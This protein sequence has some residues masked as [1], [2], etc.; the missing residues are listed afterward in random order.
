MKC[1]IVDNHIDEDGA[2]EDDDEDVEDDEEDV[3]WNLR[4]AFVLG[5]HSKW[6]LAHKSSQWV[7]HL[8]IIIMM[9]VMINSDDDNDH[10]DNHKWFFEDAVPPEAPWC[11]LDVENRWQPK[12]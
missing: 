8:N 10:D 6:L 5:E 7:K 1:R 3:E 4:L 12:S 9:M 11:L 2:E